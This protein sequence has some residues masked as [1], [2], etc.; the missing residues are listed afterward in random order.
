MA[1]NT[2]SLELT[3][4][5]T[6]PL[7]W[8]CHSL[9]VYVLSPSLFS[10]TVCVQCLFIKAFWLRALVVTNVMRQ[11][12]EMFHYFVTMVTLRDGGGGLIYK[13]Q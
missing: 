1:L 13:G 7:Y 11:I 12:D 6:I 8:F 4:F 2:L 5:A 9:G 10:Q 3:S